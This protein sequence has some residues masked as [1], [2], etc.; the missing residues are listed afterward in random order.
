MLMKV[1]KISFLF[2]LEQNSI[3]RTQVMFCL[4]LLEEQ[5][6]FFISVKSELWKAL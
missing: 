3:R 6:K 2:L 5:S 1:E 4:R